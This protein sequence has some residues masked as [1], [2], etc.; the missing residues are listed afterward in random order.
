MC[1]TLGLSLPCTSCSRRLWVA[2]WAPGCGWC[3]RHS[4]P[5]PRLPLPGW[6]SAAGRCSLPPSSCGTRPRLAACQASPCGQVLRTPLSQHCWTGG[7]GRLRPPCWTDGESRRGMGTSQVGEEWGPPQAPVWAPGR[8]L[9][10]NKPTGRVRL[11]RSGH[12]TALRTPLPRAAGRFAGRPRLDPASSGSCESQVAGP[13]HGNPGGP[14]G[15]PSERRQGSEASTCPRSHVLPW[16]SVPGGSGSCRP[17]RPHG[18]VGC[19]GRGREQR[20]G[21]A[22]TLPTAPRLLAPGQ[23]PARPAAWARR[24]GGQH[25]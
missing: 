14:S 12:R 1:R 18:P 10:G 21:V 13:P 11:A 5:P 20:T 8:R 19:R 25:L 3:G 9:A 7:R 2:L 6:V 16:D 24:P 22:L 17:P 23:A 4:A 15:P